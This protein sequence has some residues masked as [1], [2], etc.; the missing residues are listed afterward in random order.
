MLRFKKHDK[1]DKDS[2]ESKHRD[3]DDREDSHRSRHR[4]RSRSRSP[5]R[6]RSR[7]PRRRSRSPK[8]HRRDDRSRSRSP[9]RRRSPKHAS[10]SKDKDKP[11]KPAKPVPQYNLIEVEVNDR[12]GKKARVKCSPKDTVGD[13]KKLVAAQIGTDPHK[14]ILKK[15]YKEY[16]DH[17]TLDDYEIHNGMNLELYYR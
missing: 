17:I 12:L 15:W 11:K 10:S 3:K 4:H 9:K 7:S 8:R 13:F 5:R 6:H 14:I 1:V 2:V 16:K